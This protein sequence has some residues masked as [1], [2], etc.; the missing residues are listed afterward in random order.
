MRKRRIIVLTL[1]LSLAICLSLQGCGENKEAAV[2]DTPTKPAAT[3]NNTSNAAGT[4]EKEKNSVYK[5]DTGKVLIKS[6]TT[7]KEGSN[8]SY[9]IVS[10]KGTAAVLDPYMLTPEVTEIKPSI[11]T[12]THDHPDHIDYNYI[13]NDCKQSMMKEE[14]LTVDDIKVTGIAAS[15]YSG[16]INKEYPTNA[17]YVYE[18]DG[19]RIA[20]MG[21]LGQDKLTDEQLQKLGQI[22][23]AFMIFTNAPEY[24]TSTEKCI[25]VLKQFKPSIVIP[26]H[27]SPEV[28]DAACKELGI[29]ER[30]EM[31]SLAISKD[32][33]E[34]GKTKF[35]RLK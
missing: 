12:I 15:H 2:K 13:Q 20:H 9:L 30:Q 22:D 6:A 28:I 21:D 31:E 27:N 18:V 10:K 14:S 7:D 33:I 26:T 23:I 4:V 34:A 11:I 19:L 16:D 24:G 5:N 29:T 32:D 8:T 35:I 17:I 1:I 25:T 3:E